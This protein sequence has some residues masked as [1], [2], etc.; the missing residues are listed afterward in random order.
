M[1]G[2]PLWRAAGERGRMTMGAW[3]DPQQPRAASLTAAALGVLAALVTLIG[4][5]SNL[6]RLT[7]WWGLGISML[8]NT[9]IGVLLVSSALAASAYG[10]PRVGAG[11]AAAAAALGLAVLSEHAFG[12]NLGIDRLVL[13]RPWGQTA[14]A[15]PGRIGVP[16]SVSLLLLGSSL[17]LVG[18]GRRK[19]VAA[20]LAGL[21]LAVTLLSIVGYLFQ[22]DQLY[23][24]PWLTTI[25]LQTAVI[26]SLLA[27]GV[28]RLPA[29][30]AVARWRRDSAAAV[31]LRRTMPAI[32]ALPLALGWLSVRAERA[33]TFDSGFA[34]ALVVISLI[35][36]FV[37]LLWLALLSVDAYEKRLKANTERLEAVMASIEDGFQV[38]DAQWRYA[39][40][41]AAMRK[42]LHLQG[43]D[44]E[45]L[46]G[47]NVFEVFPG[48]R[49]TPAAELLM[50]SMAERITVAYQDFFAPWQR[51]LDVQASPT[52][53]G[54]IT[55]LSR[56]V[57]AA[58]LHADQLR[59][60]EE[61]MQLAMAIA[62]AA[63]WDA[64]LVTGELHWSKSHFVMLGYAAADDGLASGQMWKRALHPEDADRVQAAWDVAQ[65][66]RAGF[67][68]E[69]RFI[70]QST[71]AELWVKAAGRIFCNEADVPVRSVGVL[72]DITEQKRAELVTTG[73]TQDLQEANRNK[74]V[75]LA[76]LA[77]EL[78]NP[79]APMVSGLDV[80]DRANGNP[81]IVEQVTA[82]MRRQVKLMTRLVE[83]LLDASRITRNTLELRL[84]VV[85][86]VSSTQQAMEVIAP[87]VKAQGLS[88]EVRLPRAPVHVRG[89]AARVLQ[90]FGN[91]LTN[92]CKF[93]R[94]EG[95]L[96]VVVQTRDQMAEFSVRDDG[97][98]IAADALPRI[99]DMFFQV[100]NS[101]G[102]PKSGLGIG[103]SLTKQL[104]ELHG[105]T[106]T[107][108]SEGLGRGAEFTIQLPLL[109][110][111]SSVR[112]TT[113]RGLDL[114]Q[115]RGRQAL[116]VDDNPDVVQNMVAILR[117][118]GATPQAAFDG[119]TAVQLAHR[120][121]F[122]L[123]LLDIGMPGIS[124][125]DTCRRIRAEGASRKATIIAVSGWGKPDDVVQ[126]LAAG[127]DSHLVKPVEIES[128]AALVELLQSKSSIRVD[129]A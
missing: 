58:R 60:S 22:A 59:V 48:F 128:I 82:S 73:L 62:D 119:L 126:A 77:H 25:A 105:G 117:L 45:A 81:P 113:K 88:V 4:W 99:F 53:D 76:T 36:L 85:D 114:P 97:T 24:S 95:A 102:L 17:L 121:P 6:P 30:A 44:P 26:L 104:V 8:P 110:D 34:M 65:R 66:D 12:L 106:I 63:T 100:E 41:N 2:I 123:I 1:L 50:R 91:L 61:R 72:F 49:A 125:L 55:L 33:G 20:A 37:V 19:R 80:L 103:L 70:N 116:V 16:A 43:L 74:D 54:G 108:A 120:Q 29:L 78:R 35:V 64:D 111:T 38:I 93:S 7:D 98:G 13:P 11:L 87:M 31:L 56:D 14:A 68:S 5:A 46:L 67:Q 124:G 57:T 40:F 52:A 23:A 51:W 10:K 107:A 71:G 9:A 79:L 118:L 15:L 112:T 21:V 115:L 86:L 28:L 92:A 32:V 129:K 27:I 69:H 94:P 84:E 83:D 127:F 96:Q 47:R 90:A 3:F 122:E 39:Y 89:D 42:T 75:F 109:T 101:S 18:R